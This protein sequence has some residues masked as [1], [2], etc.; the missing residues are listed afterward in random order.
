MQKNPETQLQ[1][2]KDIL[3]CRADILRAHEA[4]T[5]D[6]SAPPP[7]STASIPKTKVEP[8]KKNPAEAEQESQ[9]KAEPPQEQAKTE[10]KP[11]A[12]VEKKAEAEKAETEA[13]AR[14]KTV[15]EAKAAAEKVLQEAKAKTEAEQE[16]IAAAEKARA[17]AK[18]KAETRAKAEEE[19]KAAV[20][21][22]QQEATA[23]AQAEQKAKAEAEARAKAEQEAKAATE[24]AQQE[25]TAKDEADEE[26]IDIEELADLSEPAASEVDAAAK[27]D[28]DKDKTKRVEVT[29][30]GG[31]DEEAQKQ[32]PRFDLAQQILAEQR[33]V[34]SMRRSKSG[35][36]QASIK[37]PQ[38]VTGTIG[39]IIRE[40]KKKVGDISRT[41]EGTQQLSPGV[42]G[43]IKGADNLSESQQE[44]IAGIVTLDIARHCTDGN[45]QGDAQRSYSGN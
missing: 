8:T 30:E 45:R 4:I 19:V 13:E 11:E 24:K 18:V 40:A 22:A 15:Q 25:A 5:A 41:G 39:R 14:A 17:Q 42:H 44:A 26:V 31:P 43:V 35:E 10:D 23:R 21:K 32:I 9:A 33:R 29:S 36:K 12:K 28:K 27:D 2:D 16:A 7:E 20:E 6:K 38:A 1:T 3:Q 37:D 34:A